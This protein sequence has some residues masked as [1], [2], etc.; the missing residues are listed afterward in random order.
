MRVGDA[1]TFPTGEWWME[2]KRIGTLQKRSPSHRAVTFCNLVVETK[3]SRRCRRGWHPRETARSIRVGRGFNRDKRLPAA[4]RLG[5]RSSRERRSS[6]AV[7]VVA[8]SRSDAARMRW[9]SY[10]LQLPRPL[11]PRTGK[12]VGWSGECSGGAATYQF[13]RLGGIFGTGEFSYFRKSSSTSG[14][15]T[16]K[17]ESYN[18][19]EKLGTTR[20]EPYGES[21]GRRTRGRSYSSPP[22]DPT[23]SRKE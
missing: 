20:G 3:H 17:D 4:L 6:S 13:G 15:S 14:Y 18:T 1:I 5:K 11:C 16:F 21:T 23:L 7:V 12:R 9:F 19:K 22:C 2:R 8:Q 10:S